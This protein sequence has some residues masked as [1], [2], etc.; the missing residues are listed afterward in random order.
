MLPTSAPPLAP[1]VTLGGVA[2]NQDAT[3][4]AFCEKLHDD[5]TLPTDAYTAAIR[6][7]DSSRYAVN[8]PLSLGGRCTVLVLSILDS[9][10]IQ[11][12]RLS[13]LAGET[14]HTG[15]PINAC[16]APEAATADTSKMYDFVA[17]PFSIPA[18]DAEVTVSLKTGGWVEEGMVLYF[19][20]AG[21]FYVTGVSELDPKVV[22]IRNGELLASVTMEEDTFN[23]N[24][25]AGTVVLKD[26]PVW[27]EVPG[28]GLRYDAD[29]FTVANETPALPGGAKLSLKKDPTLKLELNNSANAGA[30]IEYGEIVVNGTALQAMTTSAAKLATGITQPTFTKAFA[31]APTVILSLPRI[32]TAGTT[33]VN[34]YYQRFYANTVGTGG[35]EL[36]GFYTTAKMAAD[37]TVK[38]PWIAIGV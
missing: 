2:P 9:T 6:V 26:T 17:A 10:H 35:F 20:K 33:P 31:A 8:M 7:T 11:V 32:S 18:K 30:L 15:Q 14:I 28:R 36:W 19:H 29:H 22:T 1:A 23:F 24:A 27:P 38:I 25:D 21:W 4:W 5:F 3:P 12:K 34:L 37:N 13:G 16:S